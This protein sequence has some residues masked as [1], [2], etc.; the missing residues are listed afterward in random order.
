MLQKMADRGLF[1]GSVAVVQP[2]R[3]GLCD[4][5]S[6]QNCCYNHI[7]RGA[8]GTER[9]YIDIISR[10]VKPYKDFE[11]YLS[12]ADN[13]DMRFIISNT[14]EAGIV[15]SENDKPSDTPPNTFPAKL[16]LLLKR[17]FDKSL[18]GFIIL[19]CELIDRNGDNLKRCVLEY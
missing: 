1:D 10:C 6:S 2:I 13:P 19:P 3:D 16:T 15:F 18:N 14:T 9:T 11:S 5:L 7:I 12:L 4:L 8:E 17:R